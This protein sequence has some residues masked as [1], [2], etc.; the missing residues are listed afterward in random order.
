MEQLAPDGVLVCPVRTSAGE[1]LTRYRAD[2]AV[3]PLVAVRF[4]PLIEG[5][6]GD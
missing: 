4:V 1:R 5:A 3:E 2:G 6:G